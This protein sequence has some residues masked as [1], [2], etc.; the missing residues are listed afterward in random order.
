MSRPRQRGFVLTLILLIMLVAGV[1]LFVSA[2]APGDAERARASATAATALAEARRVLIARALV[3]ANR[4][5]SLPCAAP[6]SGGSGT[7]SGEDC[8]AEFGRLPYRTLDTRVLRDA[9]AEILWYVM[10]GALRDRDS[11]EPVNPQEKPGALSLDGGGNYAAV[12][13][14]PGAPVAGQTD[15]PS[16]T[17]GDYLEDG[18]DSAPDFADC[19]DVA[20]CNDRIR[21]ISVDALFDGVQ[22]RVL[23]VVADEL[24]AFHQASAS[25][26]SQRYLPYAAGFGSSE[27]D[28]GAT[29]GQLPL[30]D[31]D[32][33]CG[34]PSEVLDA[35]E[36]PDWFR[37]NDWF[38][39]VVYHVDPE[40]TEAQR[41]CAAATLALDDG[42]GYQAVI[43][44][45]GR[46]LGGQMRPGS[47]V[48]D[49]L[50]D[51]E[52]T[53]GDATY[54][55]LPLAPDDNDVLRGVRTP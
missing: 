30:A 37:N 9:D 17:A 33:D 18:N 20:G 47:G 41:N 13:I 44:G 52:N 31:G 51:P 50:D 4:P 36:F 14:A 23:R 10:D 16:D 34:G 5:G 43:A 48:G 32:F 46:A 38:D 8:D 22:R 26:S 24:L 6:D 27:C 1:A 54:V 53:D 2:R 28:N 21:G 29:L 45:A 40:C 35:T 19:A 15:R 7:F 25:S 12:I 49:Y 3:D 55:E 39:L 42:S 11:Q